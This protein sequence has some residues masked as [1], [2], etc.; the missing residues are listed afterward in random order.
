MGGAARIHAKIVMKSFRFKA[1]FGFSIQVPWLSAS[2]TLRALL[3]NFINA[4]L[5]SHSWSQAIKY[6]REAIKEMEEER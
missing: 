2:N 3:A 1:L 5:T 4:K 6:K